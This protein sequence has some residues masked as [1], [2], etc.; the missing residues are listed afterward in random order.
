MTNSLLKKSGS[1]GRKEVMTR[2]QA[3]AVLNGLTDDSAIIIEQGAKRP[4]SISGDLYA[5]YCSAKTLGEYA[6]LGGRTADF[7]YDLQM[8]IITIPTPTN[9]K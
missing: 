6:T 3:R 7:I 1:R 4:G 5:A 8:G 9:K 2:A